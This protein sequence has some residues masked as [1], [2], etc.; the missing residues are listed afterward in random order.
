MPEEAVRAASQMPLGG[1]TGGL[2]GRHDRLDRAAS[3]ASVSLGRGIGSIRSCVARIV[4]ACGACVLRGRCRR[5][6]RVAGGRRLADVRG[7]AEV[8][9]R[10]AESDGALRMLG[11]RVL[12][13]EAT[14]EQLDAHLDPLVRATAPSLVELDGVGIDTAAVLLVAAGDNADRV[15]SEAAWANLCGA[16]HSQQHGQDHRPSSPQSG[17]N[18]QA[19]HALWRIVFTRM[20]CDPRTRTYVAS[21]LPRDAQSQRSCA[22]S[23]D[24]SHAKRI[25][26]CPA[27]S[28]E[29]ERR[30]CPITA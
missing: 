1:G 30:S 22:S 19:N 18:R 24:T 8:R 16:A 25:D 13:L 20:S 14:A 23:S 3:G 27:A 29:L 2:P 26:T 4:V 6:G 11:R 28:H 10:P 21:A 12:D 7:E 5:S 9:G 15:R 17:R